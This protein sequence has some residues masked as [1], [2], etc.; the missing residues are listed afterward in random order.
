MTST[1]PGR[2]LVAFGVGAVLAA[3]VLGVG[4]F[5]LLVLTRGRQWVREQALEQ[6]QRRVPHATVGERIDYAWP[7]QVAIGPIDVGLSADAPPVVHV[8]R[9]LVGLRVTRLLQGKVEPSAIA[10][11]GVKVEAGEDGRDL[12]RLFESDDAVHGASTG[13]ANDGA[14]KVS[15]DRVQLGASHGGRVELGPIAGRAVLSREGGA[16]RIALTAVIPGGGMVSV[17]NPALAGTGSVLVTLKEV[18]LPALNSLGLPFAIRSGRMS[19]DLVVEDSGALVKLDLDDLSVEKEAL[20]P[21]PVGPIRFRVTGPVRWNGEEKRLLTGPFEL[22]LGDVE[23]SPVTVKG[24]VV[25]DEVPRFSLVA[26]VTKMSFA[27]LVEGLPGVMAPGEGVSGVDGPLDASVAFV[28][29]LDDRESWD[30][31]P[32]LDLTAMRQAARQRRSRFRD[33]FEVKVLTAEGRGRT[34]HV[35]PSS[36]TFVPFDQI[37]RVLVRSVLLSEDAGFYIHSGFDF[38]S[39]EQNLLAE[40]EEGELVRGASTISQQLAKNLFLSREKTYVRKIREAFLTVA[41]EAAVPKERLLEI[42]F[43]LIEWG[44]NLYGI[45]EAA[46]HY[47]DKPA[48]EL[49]VREAVFLATIIP[50]PVKFHMYCSRGAISETWAKRMEALLTKLHTLGDIDEATF[51]AASQETLVFHHNN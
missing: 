14:I 5:A 13:A 35:G 26:S 3:V 40:H 47:F 44:P 43:N 39:L 51:E 12:R 20:A 29:T 27:R 41:L 1:R 16:R 34:I 21:E 48:S 15:F 19:G 28:G 10:F 30:L 38:E 11:T 46:R 50:N 24:E 25:L 8:D 17:Q 9:V 31:L 2:W 32:K 22:L 42:Y 45:G 36:S 7:A 49:S 4:P 6:L 23:D 18:S 37:P 33:P